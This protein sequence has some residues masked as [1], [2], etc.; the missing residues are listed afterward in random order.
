MGYRLSRRHLDEAKY[1]G[2]EGDGL[3]WFQTI[4]SFRHSRRPILKRATPI[5]P[6]P[7][8]SSIAMGSGTAVNWKLPAAN[9]AVLAELKMVVG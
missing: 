7:A 9:A 2:A 8:K 1:P 5:S 4:E 3:P 6:S